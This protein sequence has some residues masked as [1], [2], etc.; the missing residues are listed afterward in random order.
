MSALSDSARS[1]THAHWA[2]PDNPSLP[3]VVLFRG[4][5]TDEMSIAP[6]AEA[7]GAPASYVAVR[8]PLTLGPSAYTWFENRGIARPVPESLFVSMTWFRIWLDHQPIDRPVV[9]IGYSGG[10]LFAGALLL[11]D[12]GRYR[13]VAL[14]NGALPFETSVATSPSLLAGSRVFYARGQFDETIPNELLDRSQHYLSEVSGADLELQ[15]EPSG[16]ELTEAVV[17]KLGTWLEFVLA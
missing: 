12:P 4:R 10:C 14:L 11:D 16:H 1:G 2:T 7:L 3:L 6:I 15:I 5:G 17:T 8:G 9:L 13:A